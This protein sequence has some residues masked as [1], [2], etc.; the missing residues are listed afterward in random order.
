MYKDELR[1][2]WKHV[3]GSEDVVVNTL[4][5]FSRLGGRLAARTDIDPD[6]RRMQHHQHRRGKR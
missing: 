6:Y 2:R 3:R 1:L 4:G 5:R